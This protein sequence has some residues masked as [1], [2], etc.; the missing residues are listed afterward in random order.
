MRVLIAT[1]NPAKVDRVRHLLRDADVE[2]LTPKDLGLGSVEVEEGSD[3]AEN[4]R[5]KAAAYRAV[6]ELPVLGMDTA[7]VV[8][9]EDLDPAMVRRNALGDRDESQMNRDEIAQ[10][11][12][13]FY[14]YLAQRHGGRVAASWEDA[15][16]LSL[17]DGN[18]REDRS[19]R[20]VVLTSEVH[21]PVNSHFP[22]RSM[23]IV[24]P[25]GKYVAD[26][27]PED[28]ALELQP[29]ATALKRLLGIA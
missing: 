6:T 11:I 14:R 25:T 28:E 8:P 20:P 10:A 12:L 15:F 5:R 21:G 13:D 18:I 9:G 3:I 24:G 7:F 4:A 22:M 23:Y 27:T 2:L 29:I 26:Q 19:H 17:S 1:T 16:A